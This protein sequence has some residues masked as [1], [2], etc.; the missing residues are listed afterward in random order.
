[1]LLYGLFIQY[2]D[3]YGP[4]LASE[5]FVDRGQCIDHHPLN[6]ERP[7][8]NQIPHRRLDRV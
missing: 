3:T 2:V 5:V 6:F 4:Q 1:M 7:Q 8:I